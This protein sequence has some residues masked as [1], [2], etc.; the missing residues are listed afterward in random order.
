VVVAIPEAGLWRALAL[1]YGV[2]L[3]LMFGGTVGGYALARTVVPETAVDLVA[4]V[5]AVAGL[6]GG[7]VLLRRTRHRYEPLLTAEPVV[8]RVL[9]SQAGLAPLNG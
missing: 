6:V 7:F 9:P 3:L 8:V 1:A 2:P 5:G 4:A